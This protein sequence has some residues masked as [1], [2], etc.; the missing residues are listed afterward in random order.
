MGNGLLKHR[1]QLF[2]ILSNL[3]VHQDRDWSERMVKGILFKFPLYY[4]G[5]VA[6]RFY[7]PKILQVE[8]V[9]WMERYIV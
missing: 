8:T 4:N 2:V 9:V 1:K 3:N 6:M 7:C 5:Q